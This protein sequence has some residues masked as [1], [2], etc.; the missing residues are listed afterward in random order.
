MQ[1]YEGATF[2]AAGT[3]VEM[4]NHNRNSTKVIPSG[5]T[6]TPTITG[7]GSQLNGPMFVPGGKG[8]TSSGGTGG[9][10]EEFILKPSTVYLLRVTN[11]S[12]VNQAISATVKGYVPDL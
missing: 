6:H 9:F 3:A 2:S 1:M 7:T 8:G 10:A 5:V 12:G 4:T 11:V